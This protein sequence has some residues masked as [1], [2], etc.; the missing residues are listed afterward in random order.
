MRL[1]QPVTL[2]RIA[3]RIHTWIGMLTGL[4][5][6]VVFTTGASLVY[7]ID[8]QRAL[9]PHLFTPRASGTLADAAT[10]MERVRDA[11]PQHRLSGVDAPTTSRPT[12][13]AYVTRDAGFVTVLIDPVSTE[14]LGEL[15]TRSP[16][17]ILQ[18]IHYNLLAGRTGRIIN[19][20]GA[21]CVVLLCVSGLV[22]WWPGISNLRLGVTVDGR[23]EWRRLIWEL[24]RATGICTVILVATWAITGLYFVFPAQVRAAVNWISPVTV[25]RPPLSHAPSRPG[26]LTPPSWR[27]AIEQARR[28]APGR[29]VARVVV[30]STDRGAFLVLFSD[31]SPTPAG[32]GHLTPIYLDRVTLERLPEEPEGQRTTGDVIMAWL[33]PL[34]TGTFGGEPVRVAWFVLGLAPPLLF[35]TGFTMWWTRV[36]R[37]RRR[38]R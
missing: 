25:R 27:T 21:A 29:H 33:T 34:H 10:I 3:F 16:I 26:V 2:R 20:I 7:R 18:D 14:I 28:Q 15:P 32:P 30:P 23:R 13:L 38:S 22:I 37:P 12:Y 19:G 36:V 5:I 4:Y 9:D 35:A 1:Q 11:Y 31:S 6:V 8:L 24:H 17:R